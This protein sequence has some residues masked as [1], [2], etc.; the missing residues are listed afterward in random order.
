MIGID[1]LIFHKHIVIFIINNPEEVTRVYT[2]HSSQ[3][4]VQFSQ[5]FI[6][7][8]RR[9]NMVDNFWSVSLCF[10]SQ[11]ASNHDV[12]DKLS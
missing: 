3:E 6:T 7:K 10:Q 9:G 11:I 5:Y 12:M 1:C 4:M 8:T 2:C